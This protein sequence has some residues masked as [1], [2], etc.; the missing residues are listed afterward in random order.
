LGRSRGGLTT[1][2]VVTAADEATA[3]AV[4]VVPGHAHDA[5]HLDRMLGRTARRVGPIGQV[6]GDKGFDG[7]PQ[8]EA[9]VAHGAEPVIPYKACWTNPGPLNR[10][11]YRERNLIERLFAKLK[12]FRRV[13]TRYDKLKQTFLGMIHLA[14]GFIRLKAKGNVNRA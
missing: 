10:P 12:E 4:D 8:R 11:A 7:R 14:L 3:I 1:K 13:A 2:I 6:V 5:P 9:C